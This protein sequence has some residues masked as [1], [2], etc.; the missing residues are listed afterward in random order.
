MSTTTIF[1]RESLARRYAHNHY[2]ID[3]AVSEI[4]HLPKE[5]RSNEIRFLEV[6]R[7]I[8]EMVAPR[9]INFGMRRDGEDF[10]TLAVL[11]VTPAQWDAIRRG[12]MP[13]PPGWSLEGCRLM[14]RDVIA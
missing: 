3:E 1:D 4:Y 7:L 13:L 5:A 2:D 12:E 8:P 14:P 10:H 6:N 11:D 9:P